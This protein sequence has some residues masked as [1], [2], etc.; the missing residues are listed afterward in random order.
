MPMQIILNFLSS[1]HSSMICGTWTLWLKQLQ[2]TC[3]NIECLVSPYL[4]F[5]IFLLL[6][7]I[8][9]IITLASLPFFYKPHKTEDLS[10]VHIGG[11]G[12]RIMLKIFVENV[13]TKLLSPWIQDGF[14]LHW[15]RGGQYLPRGSRALKLIAARVG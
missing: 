8:M 11:W 4:C 7:I 12:W 6:V 14:L 9:N 1:Q 3:L 15:N 10:K 13:E 5:K 2:W